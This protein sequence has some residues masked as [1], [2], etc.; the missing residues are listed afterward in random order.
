MPVETKQSEIGIKYH[1][2]NSSTQ[3]SAALFQLNQTNVKTS[4][5]D[6]LGFN[7]QAGEVRTRGADFQATAEILRNLNLIASHT[8]LDN[9]LIK[10]ARYQGKSL[11]QT[12]KHSASAWL[13]Y[14]IGSGPLRG[15]RAGIGV[16]YLGDTWGDPSNTFKVPGVTLTDLALHYDL[17]VLSA[18]LRGA[19]FS[20]NVSNLTDKRYVASCTSRL[21]CFIGQDRTAVATLG[22]R[23]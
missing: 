7:N 21:Y 3:V 11:V 20:L 10:D 1:P 23:W 19:T 16:R 15:L 12:P 13:D 22:Y 4:D 18:Q 17:G 8:Y 5:A 14:L 2:A 6:H 9:A